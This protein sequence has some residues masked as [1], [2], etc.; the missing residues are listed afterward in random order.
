[1]SVLVDPNQQELSFVHITLL[2]KN[3]T[4]RM[5]QWRTETCCW[6]IWLKIHFN[7][8]VIEVVLDYILYLYI[9]TIWTQRGCLTWKFSISRL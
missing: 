6:E 1:L 9:M 8:Y 2:K 7:N 4:L 3:I 5:S